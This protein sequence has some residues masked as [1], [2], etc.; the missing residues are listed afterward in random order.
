MMLGHRRTP[1]ADTAKLGL[2]SLTLPSWAVPRPNA[3]AAQLEAPGLTVWRTAASRIVRGRQ[4][5]PSK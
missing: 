1:V 3:E 4:L 5:G 2:W